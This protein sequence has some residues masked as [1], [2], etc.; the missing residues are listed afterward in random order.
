[1]HMMASHPDGADVET[2]GPGRWLICILGALMASI[3]SFGSLLC[4]LLS[5]GLGG[6]IACP[7]FH[8]PDLWDDWVVEMNTMHV[9]CL[10]HFP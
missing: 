2:M 9:R 3:S 1:M 5:W 8:L 4:G 10:L 7:Q 6:A